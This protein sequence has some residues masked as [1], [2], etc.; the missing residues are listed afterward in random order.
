MIKGIGIDSVEQDRISKIF[1][2]YGEKFENRILGS[3]EKREFDLKKNDHQKIRYLSNIFAAKE[4]FS[5]ALGLGFREGVS[6]R[7]IELLRNSRG[8]P[9]IKLK[10]ST[11]NIAERLN[12]KNISVTVTDTSSLSTAFVIGE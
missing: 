2:K 12:F 11:K 1:Y 4:A 5:K 3:S 6:A 8:K 7:E 10:G 9:Y